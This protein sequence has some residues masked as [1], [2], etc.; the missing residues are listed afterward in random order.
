MAKWQTQKAEQASSLVKSHQ[1]SINQSWARA[2]LGVLQTQGI[3][4]MCFAPGS[5]STPLVTEADAL[6][7]AMHGHFDERGLGFFAL[8]LAKATGQ[9]VGV[10]V[11][12][13]TAVANLL[14][15]VI[16][17]KLTDVPLILLTADRPVALTQC[18]ANQAIVQKGIFSHYLTG[19]LLLPEPSDGASLIWM[20]TQLEYH[21]FSQRQNPGPL[22]IN[23]PFS[24]PLYGPIDDSVLQHWQDVYQHWQRGGRAYRHAVVDKAVTGHSELTIEIPC[25]EEA[26]GVVIIGDVSLEQAHHIAKWAQSLGWVLLCDPQSGLSSAWCHYDVWLNGTKAWQWLNQASVVVQ[27]GHRLVS[28]NLQQWLAQCSCPYW[29]ISDEK[30]L[31]SPNLAP[32]NRVLA[33]SLAWL[34]ANHH[35][36]ATSSPIPQALR[37]VSL[38]AEQ[39]LYQELQRDV[40]LDEFSLAHWLTDIS[41]VKS[42]FVGNSLMIRMLDKV[43]RLPYCQVWTQR[44]AS[45]IDGLLSGACGIARGTGEKQLT[46]VGDTSALHDLNAL[47]LWRDSKTPQVIVIVN[48]DGGAIFDFLPVKTT[49][50][51]ALYRLP[52]HLSFEHAAWQFGLQ[53]YRADNIQAFN[54]VVEGHF[55]SGQGVL[56]VEVPCLPGG[57]K[58]RVDRWSYCVCEEI[59]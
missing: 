22:H 3:Q 43:T 20:L 13:G 26:F 58:A 36:V 47:D 38:H 49:R 40:S 37:E 44:G 39:A 32:T 6:G 53:Y 21:C 42:L 9:P 8:G 33:N 17:A 15:A 4:H 54:N 10:I 7:F 1:V 52:H 14:P 31:I 29:L 56:L 2:L 12:S 28:K 34:T 48:N 27:F 30:R 16:E 50:R 59:R 19:E 11:T 57:A 24:E 23:C 5:R 18:A 41:V 51:D 35:F 46:I 45:G 55:A 25:G